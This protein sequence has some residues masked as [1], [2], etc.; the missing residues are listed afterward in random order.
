[1]LRPLVL[2]IR[3]FVLVSVSLFQSIELVKKR[4]RYICV[5]I[6]NCLIFHKIDRYRILVNTYFQ[7]WSISRLT[8]VIRQFSLTDLIVKILFQNPLDF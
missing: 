5:S 7:A 8:A 2:V 3:S 4:N 6:C 1:M